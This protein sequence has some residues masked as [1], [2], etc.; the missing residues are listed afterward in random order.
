MLKNKP[1][2]KI[3]IVDDNSD[4]RKSVSL[5]LQEQ[6]LLDIE[7]TESDNVTSGIKQLK[8]VKPDI[9]ILDIH[10]PGKS[11][12]DFID[13]INKNHLTKTKVIMLS[14]D[15]T[16]TNIFKAGDKGINEFLFL[17]K[18]FNISELQALVLGLCFPSKT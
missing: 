3:L 6:D 14:A 2:K 8:K 1:K 11:G 13:Y 18:P 7:V 5:A 9:V 17:G 16:L 4:I 12:F 10:M 15:D